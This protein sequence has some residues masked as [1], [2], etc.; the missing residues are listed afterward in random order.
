M[1]NV[2]RVI[3]KVIFKMRKTGI[4]HLKV[5]LTSL[6]QLLICSATHGFINDVTQAPAQGETALG[7]SDQDWAMSTKLASD[8]IYSR[9]LLGS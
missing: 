1:T 2:G 7:K 4:H 6:W 8:D 3:S 5:P 9:R